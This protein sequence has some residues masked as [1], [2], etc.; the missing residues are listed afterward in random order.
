MSHLVQQGVQ[1]V[2][3]CL[4]GPQPHSIQVAVLQQVPQ[5]LHGKAA[6]FLNFNVCFLK[7]CMHYKGQPWRPTNGMPA[8]RAAARAVWS[9]ESSLKYGACTGVQACVHLSCY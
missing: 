7:L 9:Q 2:T 6:T 5:V 1:W 3:L 4:H 8:T